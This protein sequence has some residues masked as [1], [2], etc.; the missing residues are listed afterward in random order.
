MKLIKRKKKH[1]FCLL[2]YINYLLFNYLLYTKN[3][4]TK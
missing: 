1:I 4:S 2:K 3:N